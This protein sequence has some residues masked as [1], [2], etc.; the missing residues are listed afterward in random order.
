[1]KNTA[2]ALL[3]ILA[4]SL[5][6]VSW[7]QHKQLKQ[8]QA[9]LAEVEAQLQEKSGADEKVALAERK[10]KVLQEV[11]TDTSK[12]AE[13][14]TQQ[15]ERLQQKLAAAGTN[16]ANPFADMFKDP[17]MK[18]MIKSQQ[19]AVMGPMIAKQYAALFQQL[20]LTPEQSATLKD[21]L[22]QKM[23]AGA[24]AGIS[25]MDGSLDAAQRAE[26][27]KDVKKQTDETDA[28]IKEFLGDENYKAFQDYEKTTADRMVVGQ[29]SDQLA[30]GAMAL[31]PDQQQQL[32]QVMS[33]ERNG[34]KWTTDFNQQ[35]PPTGDFTA[36]FTE[37]KIN[38]F[39]E[40]KEKLDQQTLARVQQILNPDQLTA[41]QQFQ[42]TQRQL[43]M[44]GMKMAAKMFAPKSP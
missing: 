27:A 44:A 37:D 32:I 16:N 7:H 34:F 15:A 28:Q 14:K 31:S 22:Q 43:Q 40:E 13:E 21:L 36:M 12:I 38:Q 11:L 3:L 20:G 23:L 24:D 6:A 19:K 26:L 39:A 2:I 41:F 33:E 10:S 18:E 8:Q 30:D 4:C 1:M 5:G 25:M 35:N 29:F 42:T 9:Q 17:A